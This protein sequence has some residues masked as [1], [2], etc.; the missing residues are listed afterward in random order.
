VLLRAL[1]GKAENVV[2]AIRRSG[3]TVSPINRAYA[4]YAEAIILGR[5]GRGDEAVA[6]VS[7]ADSDLADMEWYRHLGRRLVA[8]AALANG[9][10]DPVAWLWEARTCFEARRQEKLVSACTSLLRRAGVPASHTDRR[11]ADVPAGFRSLGITGREMEVLAV[12]AEGLSNREI[13]ERLYLSPRTVEKH[14]ASLMA[15]TDTRTRAQLAALAVSFT[16]K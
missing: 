10:G 8:E 12:L 6:M 5:S 7:R 13:G 1:D 11:H 4:S 15:K 16:S 9:W 2:E 3:V 14:V